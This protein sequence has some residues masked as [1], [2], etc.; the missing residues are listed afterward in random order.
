VPKTVTL[1]PR[2]G[3]PPPR[4][5]ETPSGMINAVG[6]ANRGLDAFLDDLPAIG[7]VG[8]PV[9]VNVGGR[10]SDDYVTVVRRIEERVSSWPSGAAGADL[11][12]IA[13]FE[14]NV[15]CP[16]VDTG[17]SVGA[18]AAATGALTTRVRALTRRLLVVKLTPNVTD[19]V[20]IARAAAESGADALS[21]VNTV[22]GLV[23]D[24]QSLRPFLGNRT[25]GVCGPAIRPIALRMVWE[26]AQAVDVPLIGMGGIAT[27]QDALEFIACG[28][29]A[30]A[31]GAANFLGVDVPARIV[32][33]LRRELG[34][35]GLRTVAAAR[36]LALPRD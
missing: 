21:L 4:V 13:G 2:A 23:L 16:N 11:P 7:F 25:G 12:R 5:T 35:R 32:S 14:L 20:A 24:H 1:E 10:T 30:V 18:D 3:N 34:D 9:I 22:K 26:V 36:G 15:S 19:V 28:A 33:E 6:L 17:L 29:T 8:V 31:V 27:G